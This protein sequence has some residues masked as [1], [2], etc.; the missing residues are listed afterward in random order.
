MPPISPS[1]VMAYNMFVFIIQNILVKI[2]R[3]LN[4]FTK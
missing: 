4:V 3:H 1:K 2:G